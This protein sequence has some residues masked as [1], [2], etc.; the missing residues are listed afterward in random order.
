MKIDY[1]YIRMLQIYILFLY[2]IQIHG[3]S[4]ET[5]YRSAVK[6]GIDIL[7]EKQYHI[8]KG[9]R[10]GIITNPTGVDGKLCSSVDVISHLPDV[11]LVALFGPEHGFKGGKMGTISEDGTLKNIKVFSLYG[12]VRRPTQ[13]MLKGIDILVFDIQDIGSRSYTYISTMRYCMEE[14]AKYNIQ[15]VVLDRPNPLGGLLVDGP[16]LDIKFESFVGNIPVPYVYGMTVGEI[17]LFLNK[18]LSINCNLTVIKMEG[19]KRN[20]LWENTGLLW[21]P[22]SPHIPEPDTPFF[23]PITGILG[24]LGIVNVGVGY[25]LPFKLVGA[26]WI[27]AE[28]I[29]TYLNSKKL[30]GVYF[31]P[32]H[33]TPFYGLYKGEECNGFRIII[34]DKR[35]YKPVETGYH[36]IECLLSL[37]PDKFNFSLVAPSNKDMFDKVNGSN[38]IRTQ[39]QSGIK[40]EEIVKSYQLDLKEFIEKRKK[41]LLYE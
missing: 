27:D 18:E 39:F 10:I 23:Y 8:L 32:F 29:T 22:T 9:K 7:A 34:K 38:K 11:K 35:N 19:W 37:Y 28:K 21:T 2:L 16:I 15:F 33:F 17:A 3:F 31:Q 6:L 12:A 20:M 13:E 26:P 14:A 5:E 24:E 25:T 4:N 36:I 41:Y 30:P 1:V 40:T